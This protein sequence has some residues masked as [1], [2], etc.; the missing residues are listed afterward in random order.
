[1]EHGEGGYLRWIASV[2]RDAA[3]KEFKTELGWT[4]GSIAGK[5]YI[6]ADR[7]GQSVVGEAC[8]ATTGTTRLHRMGT[9]AIDLLFPPSCVAC[10]V[11]MGELVDDVAMCITCRDALPRI[12]WATCQRCAARVPEIP[13]CVSDCKHCRD[14]KIQFDRTFALGA[15]DGLLRDLVL[16]MKNDATGRL[17][18]AFGELIALQFAETIRE[19]EP[20]A[21]VPIPMHV[22]RRLSRRANPPVSLAATI[23]R[24][25]GL[26][27]EPNMLRWR[28]GTSAQLGLSQQG[29]FRNMRGVMHV[30]AGY[31][32][33]APRLLLVDDILT[34]GATC[35]EA[36]RVLKRSGAAEVTVVVVGRTPNV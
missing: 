35:S 2:K 12:V 29:R 23:G 15:Y 6:E 33:D 14:H 31:R 21:I 9:R 13:G 25:L 4:I 22:W 32:L 16:E 20:D 5:R 30:R 7:L 10:G 18:N 36:A 28:R 1:M 19:L 27:V 34:T 26:P 3:H 8:M 24:Q 17:A 11:G